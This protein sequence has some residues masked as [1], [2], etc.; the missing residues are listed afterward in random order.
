MTETAT[1]TIKLVIVEDFKL[2]RVGLRCALNSNEDMN[3][4]GESD[5]AISAQPKTTILKLS[6]AYLKRLTLKLK[7]RRKKFLKLSF[8]K[9]IK[10]LSI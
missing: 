4:V 10:Y 9:T 1:K 3:V 7:D 8:Q 2:T 6:R 5:P